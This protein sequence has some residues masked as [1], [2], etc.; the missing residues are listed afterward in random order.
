MPTQPRNLNL[1]PIYTDC[2]PTK[3]QTGL[4]LLLHVFAPSGGRCS[5]AALQPLAGAEQPLE[6]DEPMDDSNCSSVVDELRPSR[7]GINNAEDVEDYSDEAVT[8]HAIAP[9]M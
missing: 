4:K 8:G 7:G 9:N 3:C 6:K 1:E 2:V 5:E